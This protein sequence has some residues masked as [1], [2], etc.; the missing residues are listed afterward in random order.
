[1]DSET[2][3]VQY[4]HLSPNTWQICC[5]IGAAAHPAPRSSYSVVQLAGWSREEA[6]VIRKSD[7][8]DRSMS[9]LLLSEFN[10]DSENASPQDSRVRSCTAEFA[11]LQEGSMAMVGLNINVGKRSSRS[12]E[13]HQ[14]PPQRETSEE[15][16]DRKRDQLKRELEEKA[17][18]PAKK[19]RKF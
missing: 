17:K 19:K 5:K 7:H 4:D 10:R 9:G 15:R 1:M 18:A 6:T 3:L 11:L 8:E 13:R 16:A 14:T 2:S 12:T